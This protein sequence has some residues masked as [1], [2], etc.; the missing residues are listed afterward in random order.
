MPMGLCVCGSLRAPA[1]WKRRRN[2]GY[3]SKN[4]V[5]TTSDEAVIRDSEGCAEQL[6]RFFRTI[7]PVRIPVNVTAPRAGSS[8]LQE[9]V[10]VEFCGQQHAIFRTALP[11]EYNDDVRLVAQEFAGQLGAR[12]V[13]VQYHEGLKAVA[14]R[15]QSGPCHWMTTT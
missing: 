4:G 2:D 8:Q 1:S 12:V 13:A 15:F 10:V 6:A 9:N 14:V 7:A 5:R 11:L 3:R